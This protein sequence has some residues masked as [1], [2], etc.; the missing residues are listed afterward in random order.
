MPATK[1]VTPSIID[2]MLKKK[3]KPYE[4]PKVRIVD[5]IPLLVNGKVDRR[6]LL[7]EYDKI[8]I[9]S[10]QMQFVSKSIVRINYAK[11]SSGHIL[12]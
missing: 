3:L 5:E 9:E 8:Q 12:I 7:F 6:R 1:D 2:A 10:E 4:L 11:I